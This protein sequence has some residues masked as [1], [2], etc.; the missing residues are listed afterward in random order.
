[1]PGDDPVYTKRRARRIFDVAVREFR[2][3]SLPD[4]SAAVAQAMAAMR[5]AR[6]LTTTSRRDVQVAAASLLN[7]AVAAVLAVLLKRYG[8]DYHEDLDAAE[9]RIT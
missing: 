9:R 8:A 7:E 6:D 5:M 1:M 4:A 3:D 2:R